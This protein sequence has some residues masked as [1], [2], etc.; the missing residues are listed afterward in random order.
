MSFF[1]SYQ[2]ILSQLLLY[3]VMFIS[4]TICDSVPQNGKEVKE[5]KTLNKKAR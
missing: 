4:Y 5:E 1:I 2:I 3:I